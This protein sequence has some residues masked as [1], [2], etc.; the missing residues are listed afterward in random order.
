MVQS[1]EVVRLQPQPECLQAEPDNFPGGYYVRVDVAGIEPASSWTTSPILLAACFSSFRDVGASRRRASS[2]SA[3]TRAASFP[4]RV[5]RLSECH[6][7]GA[8]REREGLCFRV[9]G[10]H[11]FECGD[12]VLDVVLGDEISVCI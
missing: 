2:P 4:L 3:S 11:V 9:S 5:T 10:E 7:R 12:A 6:S 8:L 1:L